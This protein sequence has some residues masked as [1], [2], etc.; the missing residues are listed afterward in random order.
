MASAVIRARARRRAA[1]NAAATR[2]TSPRHASHVVSIQRRRAS[3]PGISDADSADRAS[4]SSGTSAR[5]DDA[6]G[7]RPRT[8][9]RHTRHSAPAQRR[10]AA[11]ARRGQRD[12]R[13]VAFEADGG[14]SSPCANQRS[15]AAQPARFGHR[16]ASADPPVVIVIASSAP[17]PAARSSAR[18]RADRARRCRPARDATRARSRASSRVSPVPP[19]IRWKAWTVRRWPMRSTRPMRCSSRIGFHGSSRL[20]TSRQWW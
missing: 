19:A 15:R 4:T 9:T 20:T 13:R 7:R 10:A 11:V 6:A 16:L 3:R 5:L 8:S 17:S 18:R 14:C 1:V 2:S 12:P